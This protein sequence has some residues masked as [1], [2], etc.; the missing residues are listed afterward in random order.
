MSTEPVQLAGA[1]RCGA[2]TRG[3]RGGRPCRSP[4]MSNGRCRMHGGRSGGPTGSRNGAYKHGRA[5][6][7]AKEV[8]KYF[9]E[10]AKVGETLLA[11]TLDVHGLRRKIP[12]ALRRRTQRGGEEAGC[13]RP[14]HITKSMIVGSL[15]SRFPAT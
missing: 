5:T 14:A 11:K 4:A 13:Y 1:R 12:V 9:T 7:R 6:K 10:L 15:D 3:A 8:S 2:K